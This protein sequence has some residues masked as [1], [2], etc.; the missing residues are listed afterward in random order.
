MTQLK[1]NQL[2]E[3]AVQRADRLIKELNESNKSAHAKPTV[4]PESMRLYFVQIIAQR[5]MNEF[6]IVP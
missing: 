4:E 1:A 6:Q 2:S 3:I 5:L